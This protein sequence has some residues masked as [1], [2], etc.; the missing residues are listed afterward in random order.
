MVPRSRRSIGAHAR[1]RQRPPSAAGTTVP[2]ALANATPASPDLRH[3]RGAAPQH[4]EELLAVALE[5][6]LADAADPQQRV[7]VR[8]P[9]GEHPLQRRVVKDHVW[10]EIA[11]ARDFAPA[12]A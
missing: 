7:A 10:R 4:L 2:P 8:R 1:N 11:L 6:R 3:R 5:L 9:L 12:L